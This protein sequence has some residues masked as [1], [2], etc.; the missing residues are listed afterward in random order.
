[1]F[2][3]VWEIDIDADDP[4]QAAKIAEEIQRDPQSIANVY[5]VYDSK[6]D[7]HMVDRATATGS[8]SQTT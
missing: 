7:L 5:A 3:V 6:G 8:G 1:M 4:V 2:R